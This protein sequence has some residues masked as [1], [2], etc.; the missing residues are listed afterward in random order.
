MKTTKNTVL[1]TG[2]SAGIGLSI[3]REFLAKGN[4]VIIT[5]RDE[6]RLSDAAAKLGGK[7]TTIVGDVS[8][9]ED[10]DRLVARV[11]KDFP[12]LNIL[13]NNAGKAD[14]YDKDLQRGAQ[15]A[16]E[17]MLV[18]Y[19]SVI[20]LT[21]RLLPVLR[22]QT[23][24]A[25]VNVTSVLALVPAIVVTTYSASKAA[26]RSYTHALRLLLQKTPVKV[27]ELLP[28]L[29]N[30]EFSKG[31]GGEKGISPDVVAE[32]LLDSLARDVFEIRVG[33]TEDI[34]KL[35]LSSPEQ[36]LLALNGARL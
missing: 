3:A 12:H 26:L 2:G 5:G 30:T 31:I 22:Q 28:P 23:E 27:F 8:K 6:K 20:G 11:Q 35:H 9:P 7:V 21:E 14:L 1:I 33:Q 32:Q 10:V 34:Y 16:G 24:A 29:V 17:E 15:Q 36:A 13:V 19:V 4:E 25:V 18:N